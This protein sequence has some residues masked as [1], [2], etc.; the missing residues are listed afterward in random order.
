VTS[1]FGAID[2]RFSTASIFGGSMSN[3]ATT[4]TA[5]FLETM[6]EIIYRNR[7]ED[8]ERHYCLLD[9][10]REYLKLGQLLAGLRHRHEM[11]FDAPREHVQREPSQ[12]KKIGGYVI[13][14]RLVCNGYHDNIVTHAFGDLRGAEKHVAE[15]KTEIDRKRSEQYADDDTNLLNYEDYPTL[16]AVSPKLFARAQEYLERENGPRDSRPSDSFGYHFGT[17]IAR[18]T[19]ESKWLLAKY[20]Y[21]YMAGETEVFC[22]KS[23]YAE[24][25]H[26]PRPRPAAAL[27][28]SGPVG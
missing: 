10:E 19:E 22:T 11:A 25:R 27:Q 6:L 4:K 16:H 14:T 17:A 24:A 20:P 2:S 1:P 15:R 3:K 28:K 21:T 26:T 5:E 12:R 13:V 18:H 9:R 23:E 8:L 7:S